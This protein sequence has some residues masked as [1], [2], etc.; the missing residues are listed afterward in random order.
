MEIEN[1]L[2]IEYILAFATFIVPGFVIM[3]IIRLKVPNKEFLLKDMIF[4]A[5]AYSLINLALFGWIPY[6]LLV[7]QSNNWAILAFIVILTI[8]PI[9]LALGYV[10]LLDSKLF[11]NNFNIQVPTAWDWYF[12]KRPLSI[13]RVHLKDGNEIIG[14]FGENSYATSF[15]NDGN[16]YLEQ[17]YSANENGDLVAIRNS[18]G[19][20]ISK[21]SYTLIEF[22]KIEQGV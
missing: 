11:R 21:E 8:S 22:Y 19:I 10:K 18:D 6:L 13:V 5:L 1:L 20:L 12:S 9:I 2:K 17:V 14:Y 15:P 4:E 16:I 7:H 3:K